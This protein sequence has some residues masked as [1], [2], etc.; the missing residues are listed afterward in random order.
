MIFAGFGTPF[1]DLIEKARKIAQAETEKKV[2]ET[3]AAMKPAAPSIPTPPP[4]PTRRT[5]EQQAE[6]NRL[7]AIWA[8]TADPAQK[9][10][11][12]AALVAYDA[13]LP[14]PPPPPAV[15]STPITSASDFLSTHW[16]GILASV[17]IVGGAG[18][19][20]LRLTK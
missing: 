9:E 11:A 4:P 7:A 20:F 19:G 5:P 15:A 14:P 17:L 6:H 16:K 12:R 10:A 13:S 3:I 1:D 8:A 2:A 18:Y